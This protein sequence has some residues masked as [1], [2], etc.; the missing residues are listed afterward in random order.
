MQCLSSKSYYMII[1]AA[2]KGSRFGSEIPKQFL[3]I[4]GKPILMRT[5]EKIKQAIDYIKIIVVLPK[6][7]IDYWRLLCR[8]YNFKIEHRIVEGADQRFF[9]VKNAIDSIE[10]ENSIV[11]VHDGVRPF[12]GIDVVR[13]S[14]AIAEKLGSAIPAINP[15]ETVRLGKSENPNYFSSTYC[16]ND[17]WLVQTPQ[18]FDFEILKKAY[19][20]PYEIAF[21][22]DAS[23]VEKKGYEI[24]LVKGNVENIKI[25][26][27]LDIYYAEILIDEFKD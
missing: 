10:E 24:N 4:G 2:G 17:V 18:C 15:I 5:I 14:M 21:T 27:P 25:T 20:Q 11:G 7:Q 26:N 3:P 12:V 1:V 23:V 9:S 6:H 13:E 8:E 19:S 22:D 16:R